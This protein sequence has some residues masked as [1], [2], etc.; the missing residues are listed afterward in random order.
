[1]FY[2]YQHSLPLI[3]YFILSRIQIFQDMCS[4]LKGWIQEKDALLENAPV[5]KDMDSIM[6]LSRKQEQVQLEMVP[7]GDK[8]RKMNLMADSVRQ[9]YPD[10]AR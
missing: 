7:I 3:L 5:G 6:E 10:E 1:M 2:K 4:E 9:S 8:I